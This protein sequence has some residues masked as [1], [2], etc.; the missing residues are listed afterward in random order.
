MSANESAFGD[1]Y[2]GREQ[3][4]VKHEILKHY[5][6]RFAH[7]V[8]SAWDAITYVDCF[9]GPWSARSD[10]LEDSSF[11]VAL[12]QLRAARDN[13][14]DLRRSRGK[15]PLELRCF[16]L[17]KEP[18]P[19]A[20]LREFAESATDVEIAT[21]NATLEQ[22]IPEIVAFVNQ[23]KRDAF[24]FIFVDPTGW[25]GFGLDVIGPLLRLS[26][27]EV[28]A[29]FMTGYIVRFVED[30]A[31]KANFDRLFGEAD[32]RA[33]VADLSG[34]DR[35]DELIRCY[36]DAIRQT[37]SFDYV[38]SA[39]ILNPLKDRTH[40]HLIYGTRRL[41]GVEVFKKAEKDAM[42]MMEKARAD[43]Q[44]RRRVTKTRQTEFSFGGAMM[45]SGDH[46]EHLRDRYLGVARDHV[47]RMLMQRKR[48]LF[49][50]AWVGALQFPLV[51][52][53]DVKAWIRDWKKGGRIRLEG[54]SP[55]DRVPKLKKNHWLVMTDESS[56]E[57]V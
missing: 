47:C 13:L 52:D 43:A 5:L 21:K 7:K 10:Q 51:W 11:A 50:D 25:T 44:Q 12:R 16:F 32:Y 55:S 48:V 37:G 40:F 1:L 14:V 54:L 35:E 41:E 42:T 29:N 17:E 6:E 31:Q 26:P 19:Y 30:D 18:Q 49:D 15:G 3:T 24:P 57:V 8:G 38:C 28:L 39:V 23:R 36:M 20:K 33:R 46:Y 22:S 4:L 45:H 2:A 56:G 27:C 9:A 53:S 34:Q